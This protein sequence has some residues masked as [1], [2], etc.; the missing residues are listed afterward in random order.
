MPIS[1]NDMPLEDIPPENARALKYDSPAILSYADKVNK[2]LGLPDGLLRNTISQGERSGP[3][4]TSPKGAKG[5][6]QFMPETAKRFGLADPTDPQA[7]IDAM[8][9][10]YQNAQ[11]VTKS[12][13]PAILAAAYN[14]GENQKSLKNGKV[15]NISETKAYAERVAGG[16]S[17]AKTGMTMAQIE[18]KEAAEN[19]MVEPE[20][21]VS[22]LVA[23]SA[24]SGTS[25]GTAFAKSAALGVV[26]AAAGWAAM[27]AG[28]E[29]G[30]QAGFVIGGPVGAAVVGLVGGMVTA[31]IASYGADKVQAAALSFLPEQA[32]KYMG[33]DKETMDQQEKDH[34]IASFAGRE[35]S[36]LVMFKPGI[37]PIKQMVAMGGLNTVVEGAQEL[38]SDG[39]LDPVK[40]GI[41]ASVGAILSQ[42]NKIGRAV[43]A[44]T[45]PS[46]VWRPLKDTTPKQDYVEAVTDKIGPKFKEAAE[47][48]WEEVDAKTHPP[49]GTLS[50]S[51]TMKDTVNQL[52]DAQYSLAGQR[53]A[54]TLD[55]LAHVKS[56]DH[57][58]LALASS[59]E[60]YHSMPSE[61]NA[62][63]ERLVESGKIEDANAPRKIGERNVE[64][65]DELLT[66]EA[67][68]VKDRFITPLT[69]KG[70]SLYE[71]AKAIGGDDFVGQFGDDYNPRI[72]QRSVIQ[73][74]MSSADGVMGS[75]G[76]AKQ[77]NA[78]K[79]RS[80]FAFEQTDGTRKV[81]NLDGRTVNGF[82][83]DK[84]PFVMGQ[85]GK[86]PKVGDTVTLGG[87][88][89]KI[90]QATTDHIESETDLKYHKNVLANQLQTNAELE[91]YI[92]E[93][94]W[95]TN[96]VSALEKMGHAVS[97]EETHGS[98]PKGYQAVTGDSTLGKYFL[99][100]RVAETFQDGIL[101]SSNPSHA[102]ERIN[103]A[104][105]GTMF[106]NPVP[107]L[108]N[109]ADHW[110]NSVGWDFVKP[111]QYK[112]LGKA[113]HEAYRDVSTLSPAYR[114]YLRSGMGLSY[115]RVAAEGAYSKMVKGIQP[116]EMRSLAKK[117]G[118]AP[119]ELTAALYRGSKNV[120][121]GGSDVMMLAAYKHMSSKTG[122]DIFNKALR[123]H[124][125]AHNPN[126]RIP[127]RIGFDTL[128]KIPGLPEAAAKAI[129]RGMSM[130]MQSKAFNV[131]GRYHYGQFKSIGHDMH[132][133]IMQN[134]KSVQS[135]SEALA[136]ASFV[137]FS[138]G[139]VYPFLFDTMAKVISGDP[140]A[141]ER[142][143][144]ASTI[145]YAMWHIVLG[146][147]SFRKILGDAFSLPP[148]TKAIV[149]GM[150]N[151]N[152]FT[153]QHIWEPGDNF[154]GAAADT[155]LW[156]TGSLVAPIRSAQD[157][158][159][160]P[161][162]SL[163]GTVGI[164]LDTDVAAA[165][166][167]KMRQRDKAAAHRR[168]KKRGYL[169]DEE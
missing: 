74:A 128:S 55:A 81:I 115:G 160:K 127:P 151:R 92:R 159:T 138:V 126:Y 54:T 70:K 63:K 73:K 42:P 155:G 21:K 133:I 107:H 146:D 86:A 85:L 14:S 36:G 25:A 1:I 26:P 67:K 52:V 98:A 51:G 56:M 20:E 114:D 117:W 153:G 53:D 111:W 80:M 102:I 79:S 142:R 8:G 112:S 165:K 162:K 168:Q 66:P 147:E 164:Q 48:H 78:T 108:S 32:L 149:E 167:F 3:M 71:Q 105:I 77:A 10:Y 125:E 60:I 68:Y 161:G 122:L 148:V 13:D 4:S 19:K 124:V 131:F 95:L 134:E 31:G 150:S 49:E 135:R 72:L 141:Q 28:A 64:P 130:V 99:R 61:K 5:V 110:M 41:A 39:K 84:K 69:E 29:I 9:R 6:A 113:M 145:P 143:S 50:A 65:Q 23:K 15:P 45:T 47:Q 121:W 96:T 106:W 2:Q 43:A 16:M 87:K 123:D 90:V 137:A 83:A 37:S 62:P 116:E 139:V 140:S 129:S 58:E 75:V 17:P 34:P 94:Q 38:H 35:V 100:D 30:A 57:D 12:S 154:L 136:H 59:E 44:K 163:A 24:P 169:M 88:T 156:I 166:A 120:L 82:G 144:G 7:S 97:K 101:K 132:D 157:A 40:L 158:V 118:M 27:G 104:A 119:V 46:S 76:F 103:Q 91:S 109:A 11:K 22:K 152:L 93:K 89:G 33:L 18:A